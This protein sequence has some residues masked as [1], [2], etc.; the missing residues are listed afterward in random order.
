MQREGV[1]E[2]EEIWNLG[3][4]LESSAYYLRLLQLELTGPL[5]K[6]PFFPDPRYARVRHPYDIG[7]PNDIAFSHTKRAFSTPY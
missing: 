5:Q 6:L 1:P 7:H 3:I 2:K 4:Y